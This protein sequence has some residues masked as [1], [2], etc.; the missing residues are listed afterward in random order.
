MRL[1]LSLVAAA[2]AAVA[3]AGGHVYPDDGLRDHKQYVSHSIWWPRTPK[4]SADIL[5]GH[6]HELKHHQHDKSKPG[7]SQNWAEWIGDKVNPYTASALPH[8]ARDAEGGAERFDPEHFSPE[9]YGSFDSELDDDEWYDHD[10]EDEGEP[11]HLNA[12]DALSDEQWRLEEDEPY[13]IVARDALSDEQWRLEE[14]EP[15]HIIARDALSDE[16]WKLEEDE[17]YHIHVRNVLSD[18]QW[19]LEEDEP[20]HIITRDVHAAEEEADPNE[21]GYVESI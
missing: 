12:R 6:H 1:A 17:P 3:I 11:A 18:E 16:Q 7:H 20:Y 21:T 8:F 13:H 19:K 5:S 14:D 4:Y 2:F 10:P 9:D 15:Y